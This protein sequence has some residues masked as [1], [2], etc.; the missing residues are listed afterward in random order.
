MFGLG[1]DPFQQQEQFGGP[2]AGVQDSIASVLNAADQNHVYIPTGQV[3][4]IV[5]VPRNFPPAMY[6]QGQYPA[7]A[8]VQL[9]RGGKVALAVFLLAALVVVAFMSGA[10]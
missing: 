5:A 9:S 3:N 7:P 10:V 2:L 6:R 4:P 8:P 1:G